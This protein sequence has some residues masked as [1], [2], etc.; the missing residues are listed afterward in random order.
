MWEKII[1]NVFIY[2]MMVKFLLEFVIIVDLN[3]IF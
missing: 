2:I 1:E 3:Y